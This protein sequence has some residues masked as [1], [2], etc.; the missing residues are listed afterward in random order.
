MNMLCLRHTAALCFFVVI[1]SNS[2]VSAQQEQRPAPGQYQ[3]VATPINH[4][5]Q[6]HV[7]LEF[8]RVKLIQEVEIPAQESGPL[9]VIPV[10]EGQ[11]IGVGDDLAQLD[12]GLARLRL[13]T[14]RTKLD[15]ATEKANNNIDVRAA[16]NALQI[17]ERERRRNYQLFS[18]GSMPKAEYDR[19]ALQ[20]KQAALQLEQAERDMQAAGK[21]A[22]VE[23]FNLKAAGDSIERHRVRSPINGVVMELRKQP[24][25]WVNAGEDVM[26]VAQ[27]DRL[28]VQGLLDSS[29]FNPHEIEGQQVTISV[30]VAR[31]EFLEFQGRIVFVSLEKYNAKS[32]VVRAEVE[33][34]QHDGRW[35]LMANEDEAR[36]R[37]FLGEGVAAR[38]SSNPQANDHR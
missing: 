24:G 23:T 12:D 16:T 8:C 33:N 28:Y 30:P 11:A 29:L 21:E 25:E 13:E 1:V 32:Y 36:M 2:Q 5:G 19:S 4:V 20:A 10:T 6:G 38:L 3:S 15:A 7:D 9:V 18:K 37:I 17:A 27:M 35:L 31:G 34:R 14:A 26:R 22:Q